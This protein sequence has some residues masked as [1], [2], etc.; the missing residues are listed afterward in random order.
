MKKI[1][2]TILL[3]A[4]GLFAQKMEFN[5]DH[6]VAKAPATLRAVAQ[7]RLAS[8]V[9]MPAML[10]GEVGVGKQTLARTIHQASS[11]NARSFASLACNFL[12]PAQMEAER[13]GMR[14]VILRT[15]LVLTKDGGLL[16]QLLLPFKLGV[17]GPLGSGEQ[18]MSWIHLD[19]EVGLI[20]WAIDDERVNG[21][22]NATAPNPVT[23]KEFSK[24]LGRA[25][26]RPAF[27]PAPKFAVALLRGNELAETA[28]KFG[29]YLYDP[30]TQERVRVYDDGDTWE[31]Y[32][33]PVRPREEPRVIRDRRTVKS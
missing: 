16:K 20:L 15:G 23:N 8:T 17:G 7:A 2:M 6:L 33:Q 10:I 11:R 9:G 26:G 19:D 1:L 14:T 25:L 12:E 31:L 32:A 5:L 18:Y 24:A 13:L 30:E 4:P 21:I 27:I 29:L 3:A 28:P 22:V